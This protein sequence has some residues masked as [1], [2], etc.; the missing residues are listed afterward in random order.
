MLIIAGGTRPNRVFTQ[1]GI[2]RVALQVGKFFQKRPGLGRGGQD[3]ADGSQR[4]S[5]E[6]DSPLKGGTYVVAPIVSNQGQ[7]LLGLQFSLDLL[8]QETI[9][10]LLGAETQFAETLTQELDAL[11]R[12]V[13]GM[14]AVDLLTHPCHCACHERMTGDLLQAN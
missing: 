5:A 3:A 14:M 11:S 10:E 7:E 9:E 2:E 12:I 1:Q 13:G 6:A 4:E 8:G